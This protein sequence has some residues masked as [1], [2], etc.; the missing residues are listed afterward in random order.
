MVQ[1]YLHRRG[2]NFYFRWRLPADIRAIVGTTEFKLSLQTTS[3]L[4][5]TTRAGRYYALVSE[6]QELRQTQIA[7]M[8]N[9]QQY[10]LKV[11]R[12]WEQYFSRENVDPN[13]RLNA[14]SSVPKLSVIFNQFLLHKTDSIIASREKRKPLSLKQQNEH[15]RYIESLLCIMGDL[16]AM[17]YTNKA[18]REAL[19]TCSCLPRRN[20]KAYKNIPVNELL[21][22]TIPKGHQI[23]DK[24]VDS[25]RKSIQGVFSY[26]I[27]KGYVTKS[28]ATG[29]NLRLNTH[30]S[31]ALFNDEEVRLLIDSAL[32]E[33]EEWKKWIILLAAYTGAR[34]SELIQLRRQDV[35][36]DP[37]SDR[38][39]LLVTD[40]AG[41]TKTENATRQIPIHQQLLDMGFINYV[42][43]SSERLFDGLNP[44]TVTHW[45]SRLRNRLEIQ[46]FDDYGNRKVFHSFRHG[47]IT[48][49]RGAGVPI[50]L[51]QQVVG[52]E[53][54]KVGVTDRYS[55]TQPL[56]VLLPVV[57]SIKY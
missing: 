40:E 3:R 43:K 11:K 9:H 14:S 33:A 35:K 2:E 56:K 48:R 1:K 38:H 24:T 22:M 20:L 6:L 44:Q 47:F 57:D 26:A 12:F 45:F 37:D 27:E 41:N 17:S 39:Y 31:F 36:H 21:E 13:Q 19:L 46:V 53:K 4:Q 50:D 42:D 28:P 29:L 55:H 10:Y 7:G 18:I 16:S 30:R 5:A 23:S 52:H 25:I 54:I 15:K 8:Q 34:R 49:S 51:I 32:A